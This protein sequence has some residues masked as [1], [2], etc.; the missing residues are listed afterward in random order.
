MFEPPAAHSLSERRF[1]RGD[2]AVGRVLGGR[3]LLQAL[4]GTGASAHVYVAEDRSLGRQVAVK[5]LRAG[6]NRDEV[7]LRR[8]QAEAKAAA[9]LSHPNVLAVHDWGEDPIPYLVT[10]L[11]MGGSLRNLLS[12][13]PRI[14]P[15]QG[16]LVALQTA[17]GLQHAH[18][19]GVVHRDIKPANL[20]FGA[21]GR[22]RIADFGIASVVAEAVAAE[23]AGILAG[24]A[25]YAAPEQALGEAVGDR[26][27][28]YSLALSVIEAV[29]GRVPLL[30]ENALATMVLRQDHDVLE[31]GQLGPLGPPLVAAGRADPSARPSA[32]ELIEELTAAA[33][34]LPRPEPL[35]LVD[36]RDAVAAKAAQIRAVLDEADRAEADRA[37]AGRT[38]AVPVEAGRTEDGGAEGDD[39]VDLDEFR[40]PDEDD[41]HEDALEPDDAVSMGEGGSEVSGFIDLD[42]DDTPPARRSIDRPVSSP[43][44]RRSAGLVDLR[45]EPIRNRDRADDGDDLRMTPI[46]R[47][48]PRSGAAAPVGRL[49]AAGGPVAGFLSHPDDLIAR[50][51]ARS[52][53]DAEVTSGDDRS[54]VDIIDDE[55]I[56]DEPADDEPADAEPT[57]GGASIVFVDDEAD[58]IDEVDEPDLLDEFHPLDQGHSDRAR[59]DHEHLDRDPLQAGGDGDDGSRRR[60]AAEVVVDRRSVTAETAGGGTVDGR[61]AGAASMAP[62]PGGRH[63]AT[64]VDHGVADR[65]PFSDEPTMQR[66]VGRLID[67]GSHR[68][69]PP[70]TRFELPPPGDEDGPTIDVR[71]EARGRYGNVMPGDDRGRDGREPADDGDGERVG[72]GFDDL[73]V[74]ELVIVGD[75]P[76]A[77]PSPTPVRAPGPG[78]RPEDRV[79][80]GREQNDRGRFEGSPFGRG[81]TNDDP[82]VH[83]RDH[84]V[85]EEGA[86]RSI[87]LARVAPSVFDDPTGPM[88]RPHR[89]PSVQVDHRPD[90]THPDGRLALRWGN[91]FLTGVVALMAVAGMVAAVLAVDLLTGGEETATVEP[92]SAVVGNYLGSTIEDVEAE[93]EANGWRLSVSERREDGTEPGVVTRQIPVA[94]ELL[95]QGNTLVVEVSLGPELRTMPRVVG[96]TVAEATAVLERADLTVGS[97]AERNDAEVEPGRVL[98]A[99][100]D[101]AEGAD[102]VEAGTVVDLAVSAGPSSV[103]MPSFVGLTLENALA[104]ADELGM[105][106]VR[107][108]APSEL[109]DEGF[110]IDTTPPTGAEVSP[111]DPLTLVVSSGPVPIEIPDVAGLTPAEAADVLT[112]AGFVVVD[113]DGPPNQPVEGTTPAAGSSRKRGNEVIIHTESLAASSSSSSSDGADDDDDA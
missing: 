77:T 75:T 47:P 57:D 49:D 110:V 2:E 91:P 74:G 7:F 109:Y 26:T 34:S 63:R 67:S 90:D 29:T 27:D 1:D 82:P 69:G 65:D 92:T 83:G 24:T 16:L 44:G 25:R 108:E 52:A 80:V 56:D 41:D 51:R 32:K 48:G 33:R 112:E 61:R 97:V 95:A 28:V 89:T 100:V 46:N 37:R 3:Y 18:E 111:G 50:D 42:V 102:R 55:P 5:C 104:Q 59:S 88:E 43:F 103:A 39:L 60:S 76:T 94:G 22:L 62:T 72:D 23:P 30:R 79:A 36:P 66:E 53:A 96:L 86:Y 87:K 12:R 8:F 4:V 10:E 68:L 73:T 106:V 45:R 70:V 81:R 11:L 14:S 113:T 40:P 98:S 64:G 17:Q 38:G 99:R 13:T 105:V 9:Q 19:L 107:E 85:D 78:W 20:L 93:V 84:P 15:S 35:P 6:L 101:G 54:P 21:D 31:V 58:Q 71:D